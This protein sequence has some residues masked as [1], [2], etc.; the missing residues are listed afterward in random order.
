VGLNL[1]VPDPSLFFAGAEGL[2][3]SSVPLILKFVAPRVEFSNLL[4]GPGFSPAEAKFPSV[5][6]RGC[7]KNRCSKFSALRSAL[8]SGLAALF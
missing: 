1:R 7:G 3:F 6:F 2:V 5:G 8:F 4:G